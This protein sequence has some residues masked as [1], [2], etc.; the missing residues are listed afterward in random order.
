MCKYAFGNYR[1]T[2]I[3]PVCRIG[4]KGDQTYGMGSLHCGR[5]GRPGVDMGHDFK[6]P[7]RRSKNQWRKIDV[8][9]RAGVVWGTCGCSGKGPGPRPKTFADAKRWY[10]NGLLEQ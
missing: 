5:C 10:P 3:C 6:V 4:W 1:R 9:L 2:Y 8:M 7:R